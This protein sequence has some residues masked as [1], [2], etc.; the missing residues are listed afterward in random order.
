MSKYSEC[1]SKL[2]LV[3]AYINQVADALPQNPPNQNQKQLT[4]TFY[5]GLINDLRSA[6]AA[7]MSDISNKEQQA[8][9]L[10]MTLYQT[11]LLSTF[12]ADGIEINNV[13][14]SM[15]GYSDAAELY[16]CNGVFSIIL[17]TDLDEF[18]NGPITTEPLP[19]TTTLAQGQ[20][21]LHDL[22]LNAAKAEQAESLK[23]LALHNWLSA[24][25][26]SNT[27]AI[28][29]EGAF[30][31]INADTQDLAMGIYVNR[32][33]LAVIREFNLNVYIPSYIRSL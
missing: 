25:N 26:L 22:S 12:T 7:Y 2:A 4:K 21:L 32:G 6:L 11:G 28:I 33:Y 5:T 8:R 29:F 1:L 16:S 27:F 9:M 31:N 24:S 10:I 14:G 23:R 3:E 17:A 30:G 13:T 20:Y 18:Y 19:D 15:P